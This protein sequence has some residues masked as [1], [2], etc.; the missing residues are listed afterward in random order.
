MESASSEATGWEASGAEAAHFHDARLVN[1]YSGLLSR[2]TAIL[3]SSLAACS[4]FAVLTLHFWSYTNDDAF[5]SLR[6]LQNLADGYGLTYNRGEHVE[7]YTNFLFIINTFVVNLF[8]RNPLLSAKLLGIACSAATLAALLLSLRKTCPGAPNWEIHLYVALLF[9]SN[10]PFW[11]WS[12]GGLEVGQ[13]ALLLFLVGFL[14]TPAGPYPRPILWMLASV[15]LAL[16]RPEGVAVVLAIGAVALLRDRSHGDRRYF[17]AALTVAAVFIAYRAIS[18]WYY[19]ALFPTSFLIREDYAKDYLIKKMLAGV[20]YAFDFALLYLSV[21]LAGIGLSA[22]WTPKK[23][24]QGMPLYSGG[25]VLL[26][27]ALIVYFGGDPKIYWRL[28]VPVFPLVVAIS[29]TLLQRALPKFP[30]IKGRLCVLALCAASGCVTFLVLTG[31]VDK[32][33]YRRLRNEYSILT[34]RAIRGLWIRDHIDSAETIVCMPAGATP[35]FAQ[36]RSY[37]GA[38]TLYETATARATTSAREYVSYLNTAHTKFHVAQIIQ[39]Q[40]PAIIVEGP[41]QFQGYRRVELSK[42]LPLDMSFR[43][44]LRWVTEGSLSEAE[45]QEL[46]NRAFSGLLFTRTRRNKVTPGF[47]VGN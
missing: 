22:L 3:V 2:Y 35:Y 34:A 23:Q 32:V 28:I 29:A 41:Q 45:E 13:F 33:N 43:T 40:K 18:Y 30:P 7:A 14:F 16:T 31:A 46:L 25:T 27:L 9:L 21:P 38:L 12:V 42:H 4:L 1:S 17:L 11:L 24:E 19:G 20:R 44:D 8:I 5:I 39:E 36:R 15:A 47:N 10:I 6:Y 37:D 26:Y